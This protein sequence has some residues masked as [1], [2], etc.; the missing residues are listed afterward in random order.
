MFVH[1][2]NKRNESHLAQLIFNFINFPFLSQK[3]FVWVQPNEGI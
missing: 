3:I 1:L 2:I